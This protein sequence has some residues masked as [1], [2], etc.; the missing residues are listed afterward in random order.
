MEVAAHLRYARLSPQ[1]TRLVANPIRGLTVEKAMK[2]LDMSVK[3]NAK[4]LRKVLGSAIANAEHNAGLDI[5][6]LKVS[7]ILVDQG[8]TLKRMHARAKG[9]SNRILKPT[10]H[11][12]VKVSDV[13]GEKN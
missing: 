2:N 5:D 1:K 7:A 4:V 9:R 3:K 12:T 10:C 13:N 8:P 11:I 6:T